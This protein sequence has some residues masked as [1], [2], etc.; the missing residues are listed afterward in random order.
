MGKSVFLLD[1]SQNSSLAVLRTLESKG[2]KCH[3]GEYFT[4][5]ICTESKYCKKIVQYP[6]PYT[7]VNDFKRFVLE[8]IEKKNFSAI[9][10]MTDATIPLVLD[11]LGKTKFKHLISHINKE[12]YLKASDKNFLIK[13]AK[14]LSV[15]YP[16]TVVVDDTFDINKLADNLDY[17]VVI[18]PS[19]SKI[20][21]N[22][23]TISLN[24][25]YASN[26]EEFIKI[27]K[28]GLKY[29]IKYMVQK[30]IKGDGIGFFCLYQN[31]SLKKYFFHKRILEKPPTGGVSVLCESICEDIPIKNYATKLLNELQWH[32]VAMVEFKKDYITGIPF[33]MEINARFWGS[34]ELAIR[35]GVDFPFE[36]Y[37]MIC[38]KR[39][40]S[41]N[42]TYRK[43]IRCTWVTGILDHFYLL[44]KEKKIY[45]IISSIKKITGTRKKTYDFVLKKNDF[46]PFLYEAWQNIKHAF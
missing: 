32:G 29:K 37:N 12:K 23:K 19:K 28:F 25:T 16:E 33:L 11:E 39:I 9:F 44:T 22:G 42:S 36:T 41:E 43:G 26:S 24:V 8:Y 30:F 20:L 40:N 2:I 13:L 3:V 17:P 5:N 35:S 15:P 18:K 38:G 31:G 1:G 14:Q 4:P 7:K 10:P 34:L 6:S 46:K 27:L 21:F 45:E